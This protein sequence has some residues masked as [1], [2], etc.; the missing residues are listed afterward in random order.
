MLRPGFDAD[1]IQQ[2]HDDQEQS[3]H[4]AHHDQSPGELMGALILFPNG[5][6]F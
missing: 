5:A 3:E 2:V 1:Y 6:H 4:T